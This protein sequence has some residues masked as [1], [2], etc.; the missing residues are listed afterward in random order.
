MDL[1][2][3]TRDG[4]SFF[5]ERLS[6]GGFIFMHEYNTPNHSGIRKAVAEFES[7]MGGRT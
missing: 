1:Y 6:N 5:Y 2:R 3:P 4:L 7:K